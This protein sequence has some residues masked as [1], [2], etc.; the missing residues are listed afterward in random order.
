MQILERAGISRRRWFSVF[1]GILASGLRFRE[2]LGQAGPASTQSQ[3]AQRTVPS[4][5][6]LSDDGYR[7]SSLADVEGTLT[8]ADKFF[9]RSHHPEPEVSFVDW[10]LRIEGTVVFRVLGNP[11]FRAAVPGKVQPPS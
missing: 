1:S 10:R 6:H 9:V 5:S 8:A 3:A 11:G 7:A 4:P 2:S